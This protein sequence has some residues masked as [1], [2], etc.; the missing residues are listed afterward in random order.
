MTENRGILDAV[1]VGA[2]PAGCGA[3][4]Q[5]SRMGMD[6][7]LLDRTGA[8]GGLVREARLLENYPGLPEPLTG[9]E[10]CGSLGNHLERNDVTVRRF[11][12]RRVIMEKG[13]F[14]VSGPDGRLLS[15]TLI[16][17]VGTEPAEF[18]IEGDESV[19]V[20]RSILDLTDQPPRS[21]VVI[22]GGEAALDYAL[23]LSDRGTEVRVAV[24]GD[25]LKAEG[26]LLEQTLSR[27][28]IS[29]LYNTSPVGIRSRNGTV[30]L[31]VVSAGRESVL[32]T[33]AVMAAVGRRAALPAFGFRFEHSPGSVSTSAGGLFLAGDASL[34]SLGQA[35]SAAGQGVLAAMMA[36]KLLRG[37]G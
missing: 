21:A 23:N 6:V 11:A 29:I 33:E 16:L 5:C 2:G 32:E 26:V 10:F 17:A 27:G 36:C 8:P 13:V 1:V 24:R 14:A 28:G 15:R 37:D 25:S 7:A 9:P 19:P 3:A 35:S 4:V 30:L 20:H 12:V 31:S 34:G 22:G 18:R